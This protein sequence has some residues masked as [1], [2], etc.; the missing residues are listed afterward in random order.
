MVGVVER[1]DGRSSCGVGR[2]LIGTV[3]GGITI[4]ATLG[5]DRLPTRPPVG[6]AHHRRGQLPVKESGATR[7][8]TA[9]AAECLRH[10]RCTCGC[11]EP[12]HGL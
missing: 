6:T 9:D 8:D 10:S 5:P 1:D 2:A 12:G 3:L 7:R 4:P 11:R